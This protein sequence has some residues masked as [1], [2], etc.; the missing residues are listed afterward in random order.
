[1]SCFI[2]LGRLIQ[3]IPHPCKFSVNGCQEKKLLPDILLHEDNCLYQKM[4]C[5]YCDEDVTIS[6]F[7][8][9]NDDCFR[10][11]NMGETRVLGFGDVTEEWD[12]VGPVV[13]NVGGLPSVSF[14]IG[15]VVCDGAKFYIYISCLLYTSPSPRDS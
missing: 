3:R 5:G 10:A 11:Y 4:R 8:S 9:H 6:R 13:Y 2:A 1:M 7:G 14:P 15:V 12:G